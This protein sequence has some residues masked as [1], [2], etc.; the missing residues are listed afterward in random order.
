MVVVPLELMNYRM[1]IGLQP[2]LLFTAVIRSLFKFKINP[3][4]CW[5]STCDETHTHN[6]QENDKC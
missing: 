5:L 4:Y 2:S 1:D 6:V 3:Y